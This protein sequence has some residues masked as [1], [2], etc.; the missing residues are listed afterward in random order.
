M[1]QQ[2]KIALADSDAQI[3]GLQ[4]RVADYDTRYNKLLAKARSIPEQEA[5]FARLNRDYNIE[6]QNYQTLVKRRESAAMS[7]EL[8]QA[9]ASG[10]SKISA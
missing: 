1:A 8:E 4:A 2:L 7:G 9:T 6:K 3:A 5:E 10:R